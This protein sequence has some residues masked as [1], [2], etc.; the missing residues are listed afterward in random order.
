M[1]FVEG[2]TLETRINAGAMA[3][4]EAAHLLIK[5]ARATQS[6]HDRGIIHRDLKPANVLLAHDDEPKLTDFG[7]ARLTTDSDALT[8]AG[9][10]LGTTALY[11]A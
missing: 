4:R 7:L 10:A 1:E 11:V 3:P 9:I 2:S 5:L 6:A 8:Q